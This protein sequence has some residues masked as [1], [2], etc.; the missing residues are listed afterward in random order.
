MKKNHLLSKVLLFNL[1]FLFLCCCKNQLSPK[2]LFSEPEAEAQNYS[3]FLEQ[4]IP[5][6]QLSAGMFRLFLMEKRTEVSTVIFRRAE[7]GTGKNT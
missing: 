6:Y 3:D 2:S 4:K 1:T 5:V 7:T